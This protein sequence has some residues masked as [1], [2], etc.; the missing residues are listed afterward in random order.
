M[1]KNT[2]N[3]YKTSLIKAKESIMTTKL[4]A[5]KSDINPILVLDLN[6]GIVKA[7]LSTSN[8]R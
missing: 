6:G 4:K 8:A 7:P 3:I 5:L 2:N 1:I